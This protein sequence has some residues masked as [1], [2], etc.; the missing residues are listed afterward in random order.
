MPL[1][2]DQGVR[3]RGLARR[4]ALFTDPRLQSLSDRLR[5]G[6]TGLAEVTTSGQMEFENASYGRLFIEPNFK[7]GSSLLTSREILVLIANFPQTQMR[8]IK[9]AEQQLRA[10][11]GRLEPGVVV[12]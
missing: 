5:H 1:G 6:L 7:L 3:S 8:T 12:I 11:G 10:A 4:A 2:R 9:L